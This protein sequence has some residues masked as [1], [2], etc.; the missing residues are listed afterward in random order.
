MAKKRTV[1]ML[2][3]SAALALF[4]CSLLLS[5]VMAFMVPEGMVVVSPL[6]VVTWSLIV[7]STLAIRLAWKRLRQLQA[8]P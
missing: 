6:S 8:L 4:S 1:G 3:S 2:L 7:F 5:I